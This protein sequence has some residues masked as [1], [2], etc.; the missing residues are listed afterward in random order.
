MLVSMMQEREHDAGK[1]KKQRGWWVLLVL[2]YV[3]LCFPQMYVRT[4]PVVAGFPFF[5]WYQFVWVLLTSGLL[6]VYYRKNRTEE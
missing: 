2:P 3:G 5:Y 1:R 6:W 4:A